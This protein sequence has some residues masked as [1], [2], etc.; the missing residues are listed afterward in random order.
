M[1]ILRS[2]LTLFLILSLLL[3]AV[4]C[5]YAPVKSSKEELRTVLTL[6]GS[7]DVPYELYRF[8]FLSE[9]ALT[10]I[11]PATL[12]DGE[13]ASL[14]AELHQKTVEEISAVYAVLKLCDIYGIDV[15]SREFDDY[16]KENVILAVEGNEDYLGYGDHET[17]LAEIKAAYMNDSVFRF[18]LRYS[19]AEQTLGAYLR[20]TGVLASG[21]E[22]VLSYMNSD[23]CVRVSWIYIPYTVLPGYTADMLSQMEAEA[24]AATDDGFLAM[25]HEVI[26]DSYTDEELDV[27]FYIGEYQLDPYYAAL[28]ETAFALALGETSSWIDAGD[29]KYLV[30]R[31]PKD[32]SYL[33]D[34]K[35]LPDFTEYYLLNSFYRL[36]SQEAGRLAQ[37]AVYTEVYETLS[38]DTVR[39]PE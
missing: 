7:F 32:E 18:L 37:T 27:G 12:N 8:Y 11:D 19:H 1:K 14:F 17:Y 21:K 34:E 10:E 39:M 15:E 2:L 35:N 16:V 24:K 22:N 28:T 4:G 38:L 9:L 30:R 5:G 36:L 3:T 29:G 25:T 33:S 23:D 20:D 6:D 13:K 31:L 26:P